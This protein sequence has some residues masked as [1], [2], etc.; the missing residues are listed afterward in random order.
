MRHHRE[1]QFGSDPEDLLQRLTP[2]DKHVSCRSTH[3]ELDA[4]DRMRVEQGEQTA[5]GICRAKEEAVVYV[6]RPPR[7]FPLVVQRLRRRRLR[8]RIRH[9]EVG[10]HPAVC[11]SPALALDVCFLRQ[12]RLTEVYMVVDH[13]GQDKTP[14]GIDGLVK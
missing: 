4:G 10:G 1:T 8:K 11:G 13:A 6:A 7:T 9:L 12:S 3:E 14:R 5:V 2:V